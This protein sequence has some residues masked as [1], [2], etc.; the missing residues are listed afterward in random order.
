MGNFLSSPRT[1]KETLVGDGNGISYGVSSMQ[2]WR[3][4]MEDAHIA[5]TLIPS[6]DGCSVFAVFDGHG[7]KFVAEQCALR[8]VDMLVKHHNGPVDPTSV[9]TALGRAFF[10][11]DDDLRQMDKVDTGEDQSGCTALAAFVTD[12]HVVVANSGDS[13]GVLATGGTVVE[14]MSFDHK[15][16]NPREKL[17]IEKAGGMVRNNRV[18]GDLAVS[19]ALG[20]FYFKERS[21]LEPE[22]QQ[23]EHL[24]RKVS[25]EP[26]IK[27]EV[28]SHEN[29]FLLLACDGVWDV[30][31][32]EEACQYVRWL[33]WQGE[34]DL[35][36]I[37]EEI[38]DQCLILGSR[39][40]MSVVLVKFAGA[41]IGRGNGV[42][43]VRKERE[44]AAAEAKRQEE[45]RRRLEQGEESPVA[46]PTARPVV[47]LQ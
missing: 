19:R 46:T 4:A 30:M 25:A 17:R 9:G 21:D 18:N 44:E 41:K 14:P 33:M 40:N 37:C 34:T 13:R 12:T 3:S 47:G 2:G 31:S 8:L 20:D 10:A 15:P 42:M 38:L 39:D 29:E 36:L 23:E 27:V 5:Q 6:F 11:L 32:N 1:E 28:R 35:G 26:D 43:G 22:A 16:N 45:R 24:C 7:G